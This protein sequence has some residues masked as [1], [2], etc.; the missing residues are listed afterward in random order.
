MWKTIQH[1]VPTSKKAWQIFSIFFFYIRK[2]FL[3]KFLLFEFLFFQSKNWKNGV[4]HKH[5]N[6]EIKWLNCQKKLIN[7]I[8]VCCS[9]DHSDVNGKTYRKTFFIGKKIR[10][11]RLYNFFWKNYGCL[12]FDLRRWTFQKSNR[13]K[14]AKGGSRKYP[15]PKYPSP[16]HP[17]SK[18]PKFQ[19]PKIEIAIL[20]KS[21]TVSWAESFKTLLL[22]SKQSKVYSCFRILVPTK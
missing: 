9:W 3:W 2:T 21:L 13:N 4:S 16:K 19:R 15:N 6:C 17:R 14:I 20:I 7:T 18:Y 11:F 1:L 12:D 8:F 22:T 10:T 5:S